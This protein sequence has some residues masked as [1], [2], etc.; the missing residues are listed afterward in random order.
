MD[1][2]AAL[3][4]LGVRIPDILLPST[5]LHAW[6]VVACDQFTSQPDYWRAGRAAGRRAPAVHAEPDLP[7]GLPR[8]ARP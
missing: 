7:R 2:D 5:D 8:G 4:D 3:A 6:A 1:V